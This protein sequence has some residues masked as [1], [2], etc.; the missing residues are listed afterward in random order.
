M[1]LK[2]WDMQINLTSFL[3]KVVSDGIR[4]LLEEASLS[5]LFL[6]NLL[7]LLLLLLF[8]TSSNWNNSVNLFFDFPD[9]ALDPLNLAHHHVHCLIH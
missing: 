5:F 2:A 8:H 7:L 9:S 4:I 3:T 1:C 6:D